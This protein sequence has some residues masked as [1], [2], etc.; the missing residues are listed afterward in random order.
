MRPGRRLAAGL[1]GE[2][3]GAQAVVGVPQPA[4]PND[5]HEDRQA[6]NAERTTSRH[7]RLAGAKS[8]RRGA[9]VLGAHVPGS[10]GNLASDLENDD[11]AAVAAPTEEE[12]AEPEGK[13]TESK[14]AAD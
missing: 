7:G 12:K 6:E 9:A 14:N 4:I 10:E 13:P 3:S 8:H 1:D 2:G 11:Q 5:R